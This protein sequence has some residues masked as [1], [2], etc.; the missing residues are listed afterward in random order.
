MLDTG[1]GRCLGYD[2]QPSAHGDVRRMKRR[3]C[4]VPFSCILIL[5]N[6]RNDVPACRAG[7]VSGDAYD[8]VVVV[9]AR[10]EVEVA[11]V[12]AQV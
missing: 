9:D 3:R 7:G 4:G 10:V 5:Y 8:A 6:I 1:D 12:R 11:C 2:V